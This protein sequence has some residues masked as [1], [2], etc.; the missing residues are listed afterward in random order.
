M[1]LQ[2]TTVTSMV[3]L[4]GLSTQQSPSDPHTGV[5]V[6]SEGLPAIAL[7]DNGHFEH[8]CPSSPRGSTTLGVN[9]PG[10]DS[11]LHALG[12]YL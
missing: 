5:R 3:T 11:E 4:D 7:R 1:P 6:S 2:E 10:G 8:L 9:A 12:S